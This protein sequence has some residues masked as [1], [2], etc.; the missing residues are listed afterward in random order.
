MVGSV[1]PKVLANSSPG[2]SFGNPGNIC[3]IFEGA[4]LKE[5]SLHSRNRN[6]RRNSF[7][8]VTK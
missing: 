3:F 8:V 2:L 4:T 1:T 5:L 7:R 6:N